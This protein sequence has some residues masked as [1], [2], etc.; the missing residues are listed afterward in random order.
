[1]LCFQSPT[2]SA[3]ETPVNAP[4]PKVPQWG[5]YREGSQFPEPSFTHPL[6]K[7]KSCLSK[8][9]VKEPPTMFFQW[10]LH[11][12]RCSISRASGL[13]I[14]LY[15]SK[16]PV[17][18]H[19]HKIGGKHTVTVCRTP[20]E[21]KAYIQW[22]AA[23]FP[24]GF[25]YDTAITT[26][27]PCSLQ[28]DTFLFGLGRPEPHYPESAIQVSTPTTSHWTQGMD[29]LNPEVQMRGWV[30]GKWCLVLLD[31]HFI[32]LIQVLVWMYSFDVFVFFSAF[33]HIITT[34][35]TP[36]LCKKYVYVWNFVLS[37]TNARLYIH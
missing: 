28:H 16:S 5:Q 8:S 21:C 22:A 20:F 4:P 26:P 32:L 11:V 18:E 24:K 1:M 36:L 31:T 37:L 14:H 12:G 34:Y 2:P 33:Y 27:M 15:L 17:K 35:I 29:P 19:S 25:V 6:M 13:F 7:T 10:G 30:Y 23:W 3:S 9:L